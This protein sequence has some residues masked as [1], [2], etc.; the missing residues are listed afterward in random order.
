M[1]NARF[2]V[3][4][5]ERPASSGSSRSVIFIAEDEEG[6]GRWVRSEL[7]PARTMIGR[8]DVSVARS[9]GGLGVRL[10]D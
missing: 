7:I 1:G 10:V 6:T 2:L 8:V 4:E 5:S 9:M 3:R